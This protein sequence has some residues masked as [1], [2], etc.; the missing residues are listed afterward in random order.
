MIKTNAPY[1]TVYLKYWEMVK[2]L[3]SYTTLIS[4]IN[5]K[6]FHLLLIFREMNIT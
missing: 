3:C 4:L 1:Y 6:I 5:E 2:K